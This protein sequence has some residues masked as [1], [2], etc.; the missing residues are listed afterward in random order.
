MLSYFSAFALDLAICVLT[1]IQLLVFSSL[2][3]LTYLALRVACVSELWLWPVWFLLCPRAFILA[4]IFTSI[5]LT[6]LC[7]FKIYFSVFIYIYYGHQIMSRSCLVFLFW[8][9]LER[10]ICYSNFI[11]F[12]LIFNSFIIFL[13]ECSFFCIYFYLDMMTSSKKRKRNVGMETATTILQPSFTESILSPSSSSEGEI[14][15]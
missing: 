15:S 5:Y 13:C 3:V 9:L 4:E 2:F 7:T 14:F 10:R 8:L 11:P 6:F 12:K 1:Y